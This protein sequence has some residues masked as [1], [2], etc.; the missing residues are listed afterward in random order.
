MLLVTGNAWGGEVT[1]IY[2]RGVSTVW[3][4]DDY[5]TSGTTT[6][7]W[8]SP[9][10]G[11]TG[12][13]IATVSDI[14][15]LHIS[16]RGKTTTGTG[17]LTLSRAANSI[18]TID[19]VIN[20]GSSDF[21]ANDNRITFKYGAFTLNYYTRYSSAE[22]Y[23]NSTRTA[24]PTLANNIDLTIHLIVN[25]A[26]GSISA[27]KVTR[28]DTGADII[29][30]SEGSFDSGTNYD[31]AIFEAYNNVSSNNTSANMKS[32]TV[33]Q[34]TQSAYSYTVNAVDGSDNFLKTLAEG[35]YVV[36]DPGIRVDY[37]Q[38]ILIGGVLY[39]IPARGS[40]PRFA[41]TI[42]P[43]RDNYT[44]KIAYTNT[45]VTNVVY[46]T[47]A[48]DVSGVSSANNTSWA[49]LNKMGYTDN[50][51][52]YKEVTTL[53]AGRYRIY[54]RGVNGNSTARICNFKVGDGDPVW[55]FSI[56][57]SN[58]NVT[59][60]SE[61]FV[62]PSSSTLYFASDGSS[63]SG[64]DWFYIKGS[65]DENTDVTCLIS[66]PDMEI[67]GGG[68]GFQE[69]VRDWNNT[70]NVVNYRRLANSGVTNPS[71]AF[72]N[73][74]CF[75]NWTNAAVGL[76]GQ[77]SQTI[78]NIPNGI[79]KLQLAALVRKVNGQFIYGKSNGKTY[80]TSLSGANETAN[81]YEVIVVVEDNQLEIGLDMNDAGA[82]TDWA[83][84][85]N[86]RL[87]YM[88]TDAT[89]SKTITAA[90]WA[91]YC[92]PYALDLK[93]ATG[94]TDAY[95]VTGGNAGV[96]AMTSVKDGTVPANTGLLLKGDA[97]TVTIPVV[98]SS[99]TDVDDNKLVGV[100]SNTPLAAGK[101]YV[102]MASPKL[103]FYKNANAFTVGANTAYLPIDFDENNTGARPA[104]FGFDENVTSINAIEATET[105]AGALK[106]GKY[107]IGNKIVLVKNGMKYDANGKKLN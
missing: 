45:P 64:C 54:A 2:E 50:N 82:G 84:I 106:D 91:T 102:L 85:D 99:S 34:E 21:P 83:A 33:K 37:P 95:I 51:S 25:S 90:G 46:H 35:V 16:A 40:N 104:F 86:A 87:T 79:Y 61:E 41:Q 69:K 32:F 56:T 17:T 20:T 63:A 24:L 53:P 76:V 68:T 60:N 49:S 93:N 55:S 30:I 100:T 52:T 72:T 36:G 27:L 78:S 58:T 57:G 31:I 107:L 62:V 73:T 9:S 5:T 19:A 92:S 67:A 105:E 14:N 65:F 88:P 43:D 8:Y 29:D 12:V 13:S 81:D 44:V 80:K 28:G 11:N 7:K 39:S 59:G 74:Y 77:M 89:V 3:S 101:G 103:G 6:N 1:T 42:T 98:A 94:L 22:Y 70:S 47:E 96:L 18:V 10:T 38:N 23:I 71:G 26:D 15:Y 75:E 4:T 66:N 97:G 48:E